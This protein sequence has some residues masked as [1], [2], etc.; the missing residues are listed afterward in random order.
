MKYLFKLTYDKLVD[1]V[2]DQLGIDNWFIRDQR[3]EKRTSSIRETERFKKLK[4]RAIKLG[5]HFDDNEIVTW[6]D[7]LTTMYYTFKRLNIELQRALYVIQEFCVPHSN[8]RIDY[9]LLI[10]NKILIVEFSFNQLGCEFRYEH[11]LQQAIG[12]KELLSTLLPKDI[13]IGTYTF[14]VD[15]ETDKQ[16]KPLYDINDDLPNDEKIDNFV[17]V[18]K[19]FFYKDVDMALNALEKVEGITI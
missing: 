2:E 6:L 3:I 7:T 5:F 18:I 13:E 16:G 10:N 8:K 17:K 11:K 9:I 4:K 1:L 15:P 12:Y 19:T 14:M